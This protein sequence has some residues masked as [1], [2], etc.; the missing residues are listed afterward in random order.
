MLDNDLMNAIC[1]LVSS[2]AKDKGVEHGDDWFIPTC[3]KAFEAIKDGVDN[4]PTYRRV[5]PDY[6]Y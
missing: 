2:Y 1:E 5:I 6:T 4:G 3:N